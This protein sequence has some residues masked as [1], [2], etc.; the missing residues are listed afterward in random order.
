MENKTVEKL[1]IC[2]SCGMP[3]RPD[4]YGT[5]ADGS[6]Q[7]KYC[8]YCYSD[9]HFPSECTMEE[10]ADKEE[11]HDRDTGKPGHC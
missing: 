1:K 3:M 6:P 9:G 7:E 5:G 11:T 8:L 2:Q 4:Q 10:M